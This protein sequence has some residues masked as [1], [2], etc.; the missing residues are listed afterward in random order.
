MKGQKNT[1]LANNVLLLW[2]GLLLF[3]SPLITSQQ[4][5]LVAVEAGSK[6]PQ[7]LAHSVAAYD[8]NDT[9]YVFGGYNETCPPSYLSDQILRYTVSTDSIEV[10][11]RFPKGLCYGAVTSDN[12]GAYYFFGGYD[13]FEQSLAIYK[14]SSI[15]G[16]VSQVSFLPN[17]VIQTASFQSNSK[18]SYVF[19]GGLVATSIIKFDTE[20]DTITDVIPMPVEYD[21]MLSFWDNVNQ[22]AYIFG[23]RR[24]TP[25]AE[26]VMVFSPESN[27]ITT[28]TNF[29]FYE[30][31]YPTRG[32]MT[33]DGIYGYGVGG[34]FPYDSIMQ[35]HL[36]SLE[37]KYVPVLNH[38]G[39]NGTEF[40]GAGAAYVNSLNRIYFF[41]GVSY[42]S[43][44]D[45][46]FNDKIWFID[47]SPLDG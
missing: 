25:G 5:Y 15:S 18:T 44:G 2:S 26:P 27:E 9:I 3:L 36:Q 11:A 20:T 6:L 38:P 31:E 46:N 23:S 32:V 39:A 35:F 17:G 1:V 41:G 21:Q 45:S 33:T 8:G 24:P 19:G 42:K 13:E 40:W 30:F 4:E 16:T 7:T 28:L 43:G 29:T 12:E 14:F 22:V 10:A 47:L 37:T 34:F